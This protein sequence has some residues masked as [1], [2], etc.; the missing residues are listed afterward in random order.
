[1]LKYLYYII[2]TEHIVVYLKGLSCNKFQSLSKLCLFSE[3]DYTFLR[4]AFRC[5]W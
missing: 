5:K 4:N 2:E 1:M 3:V